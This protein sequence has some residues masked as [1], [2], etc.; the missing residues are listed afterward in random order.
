ML[1]DVCVR[2]KRVD[3]V[4][5]GS[6]ARGLLRQV[7]GAAAAKHKHVD[8]GSVLR[9][10]IGGIDRHAFGQ[11]G[12]RGRVAT[13]EQRD[14]PHVGVLANGQLDATAQV[15]VA[16]DANADFRHGELLLL[17]PMRRFSFA[18]DSISGDCY[19]TLNTHSPA[20]NAAISA[21]KE[22]P[23]RSSLRSPTPL[24]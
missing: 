1:R 5:Q 15:A 22:D 20:R 23:Y 11:R 10:G 12:Q 14:Q 24:T 4:V 16:Q 6:V 18:E 19:E 7:R 9:K 2:V 3:Y 13:R 21:R 8:V 17:P